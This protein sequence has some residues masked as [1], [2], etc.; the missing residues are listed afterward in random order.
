V[1]GIC[2]AVLVFEGLV[3]FFATLVA[4][5]LTDVDHTVVWAVGTGGAVLCFVL[6]GLV[7][8]PWGLTAGSVLQV[9]VVATGFVVPVM[10]FLGVLFGGLWF[11]VLHLGRKVERLDAA[12]A[13]SPPPG[14]PGDGG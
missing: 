14:V 5:D 1:R 11:L 8:R 6:A 12:R 7:R 3:I 4:L 2:A 13:A 9:A 10:F